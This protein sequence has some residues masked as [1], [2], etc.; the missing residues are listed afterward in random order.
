MKQYSVAIIGCGSIGA[1]KADEY[2]RPGGDAILTHAHAF[3]AHPR[4][5]LVTVFDSN[6]GTALSAGRKWG[7][8]AYAD[9]KE[10]GS[11]PIDIVVVATP[12]ASHRNTLLQALALKPRLVVAEKPFCSNLKE[13]REVHDAYAAAGIPILV[14]Y[15][16]RFEPRH[17]DILADIRDGRYGRIY[18]ARCLYGRGLRRDGCHGLDIFNWVFGSPIGLMFNH[19]P[20]DDG[21][22]GDPSYAV[23]LEYEACQEVYMV[24]ADSR[25]WGAFELEFICERGVIAFTDWGKHVAIR[26]PDDEETFG[27]YQALRRRPQL[28][29]DTALVKML[30]YMVDNCVRHLDGE[31]PL[32]C[33]SADAV[34]VHEILDHIGRP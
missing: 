1:L 5:E 32:K 27:Q 4:T 19:N 6:L 2:D 30:V 10:L 29:Q 14:N 26:V 28:A 20:I 25:A 9:W 18:H 8:S 24:T 21:E 23:H 17:A 7:C 13:A 31:E 12:T 15:S 3:H 33:T 22:P 34:R 16:R 11:N